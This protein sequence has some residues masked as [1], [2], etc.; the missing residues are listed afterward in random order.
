MKISMRIGSVTPIV[1]LFTGI[2]FSGAVFSAPVTGDLSGFDDLIAKGRAA[3]GESDI[4]RAESAYNQACPADFSNTYAVVKLVTCDNVLASVDEVRGNLARAKQRYLHAVAAAKQ[5]GPAYQ[6]LYCARLIDLGEHYRRQGLAAE[7]EATLLNSVELARELTGA[8]PDLLPLALIRLGSVYS[9]SSQP[10]RGRAPLVEA[11]AINGAS[12]AAGGPA[13]SVTEI[14]SARSA[15]GVIDLIGGHRQESEGN[16]REAVNLATTALGEDH[17]VT[18]AYQTNL[19]FTLLAERQFDRAGLL[20]RR[21]EFVFESRQRPAGPELAL[22]CVGMSVVANAEDKAAQ[23]ADYARRAISILNLQ[24]RMNTRMLA[25]AQ[26]TLAGVF[27]RNR[28][29]AEAEKILPAAVESQRQSAVSP[30]TLA[31]SVQLLGELRAQQRNWHAAETLF[32]EAIAIY[33][34]N[35]PSGVNPA[36]A[37]LL[38]GLADAL[39]H[40]GG[41]K[42]EVRELEARERDI[43]RSA[44]RAS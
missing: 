27:V 18:A 3:F 26:V 23:A 36:L 19:A 2:T 15:L 34:R 28:N 22:I 8:K 5:A 40:E 20:L 43:M 32:R 29:T 17:P 41:S 24:E 12:R 21:A 35:S 37:P 9:E 42:Q 30:L 6:P 13:I 16:L 1:L 25:V 33:G 11:M 31:A 14:A 10:E 44:P 38:R 7:A 39:K 4:D